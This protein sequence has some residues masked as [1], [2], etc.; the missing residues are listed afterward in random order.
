MQLWPNHSRSTLVL[1]TG[2]SLIAAILPAD[3]AADREAHLLFNTAS[4][5][6]RQKNW[7]EAAGSF[8]ELLKKFPGHKD[9]AEARFAAGYCLNRVNDHAAAVELLRLAVRDE[10]TPWSADTSFYLGR[11][12]EAL[13]TAAKDAAERERRLLEA[14]ESYGRAAGLYTKQVETP[15]APREG[16]KPD[17][18]GARARSRDFWVLAVG[19]Q[20]EALYQAEKHAEAA[21]ALEGLLKR[22]ADSGGS[23]YFHRGIYVLGLTR[24][25]QAKRAA[26]APG[27]YQA[28][29]EVLAV[30]AEPRF[31]KESLWE[32]AAFLL[33]RLT[34]QDGDLPAAVETYG[35]VVKRGG[36]RAAEA[37][38]YRGLALYEAQDAALLAEAREELGRFL[39]DYPQNPLAVKARFYEGLSAFD[40]K[41]YAACEASFQTVAAE[42]QE[43]AGRALLRRGQ[44]LLLKPSPNA[45]L[46]AETLA[47]AGEVL[48]KEAQATKDV[49][50]AQRAAE[51]F[52][53][54]G[55]ALLAQGGKLLEA[56][57]AYEAVS[58]RH[59]AAAPDLA[60][61]AQYQLA[62]A[63]HLAGKH[64]ESLAAS[65]RY[66]QVFGAGQPLFLGESLLLAAESSF[67]APPGSIPE[68]ARRE[69]PRF[70]AEAAARLKDPAEA[71]RSRYMQGVASY[72]LAEYR[73]AAAALEAVLKEVQA[74]PG[75]GT[76]PELSF[77]LADSLA[78]EPRR[79]TPTAE[80]RERWKR[81]VGHYLAYLDTSKDGSHLPSALVNLGLCQE[82]LENH[83]GARKAFERF[84]E[85][86]PAHE[87]VG[88]VRF[89]LGNS[90]LV[91]GDLE[92]AALAYASA[93]DEGTAAAE[94][95]RGKALY[96]KAMIER[97]L[98]KPADAATTLSDLLARHA[99]GL[100][101][102]DAGSKLLRDAQYQRSVALLEAGKGDEA[103]AELAAY[104]EKNPGSTQEGEARNQL[105]RS[106]LDGGKP[107]EALAALE[108]LIQGGVGAPGR[109]QALYLSAWCHSALAAAAKDAAQV[110][111]Q[112][113]MEAA[114]RRLIGEHPQSA[115]ATDAMLE[116]GQHLFNRK[117][118]AESKKWLGQVREAIASNAGPALPDAGARQPEILERALF[119]LGFIAYEEGDFA[120]AAKLLDQVAAS[121]ASPLAPR[122]AFQA[123]RALTRTGDQAQAAQRFARVVGEFAG[124]AKDLQEESLLRLGECLHQQ[125]RYAEAIQAL[126][127]GLTEFPDGVLRHEIR[128]A[129]GF[130]LELSG[131]HDGAVEAFRAVVAGTRT[132]VAARAQFHI[133]ECRME[134]GRH[135]EAAK[136]FATT[137]AN[138][139]FEGEFSDWVRRSLLS[140]GIAFQTAGDRDAA[141]TQ[142]REVVRRFPQSDEGKAASERLRELGNDN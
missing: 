139:D 43:L 33:G 85:T 124:R 34:H 20:G 45:A 49:T 79:E 40:L 25:A 91:L 118:Y 62:R 57:A 120:A 119:G 44:S 21:Q 130:A 115:L 70:Y 52:Y 27:R 102:D 68:T 86:F 133:G 90:K 31:E 97:R 93:A 114:Y 99:E 94:L 83:D 53:W 36:S 69:A 37:L 7:R 122:A 109:D 59:A 142:L 78:L 22:Q 98:G 17:P 112:E 95:L 2:L 38:Y 84:I 65:E 88:Q 29:R 74:D 101:G 134:Q 63:Y 3:E 105:A 54:Q 121:A 5:F 19:A 23:P 137:V 46:A 129:R 81:A 1:A 87:L 48:E 117:A 11:S 9:A 77:Y 35:R 106:L 12:L 116:L 80:D 39:K 56:A 108:P 76:F 123:G 30:A 111:Q 32:E 126:D 60:E 10:G 96:Q 67:H 127:R 15:P 82:W 75:P 72:F 58:T 135:R 66:R 107:E 4:L 132:P 141:T 104:L 125:A 50:T 110:K 8:Q 24:H 18:E 73:V 136:E 13:G 100:K 41:D 64:R 6:Y 140:A 128:F 14:A 71:R 113:E 16:E 26:A 51:A 47:K 138:F 42:S 89:E 103:R 61:K 55:E 131:D 28:T 92:G